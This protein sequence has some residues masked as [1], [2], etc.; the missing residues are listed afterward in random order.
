MSVKANLKINFLLVF[1]LWQMTVYGQHVQ[2]HARPHVGY[3]TFQA[4]EQ[5]VKEGKVSSEEGLLNKFYYAFE[6]G[7]L[8]AEYK[9]DQGFIRCL[10][11]VMAEYAKSNLSQSSKDQIA[12]YLSTSDRSGTAEI[13]SVLSESEKFELRY[14]TSGADSVSVIDENENGIPDYIDKAAAY[15]DS[16]WIHQVEELGFPDFIIDDETYIIDFRNLSG[17]LY[18][19]TESFSGS[20][21][22]VVHSTFNNF[23]RNDD[24]EGDV[25][26]ALKATIAHEMKHAI[27]YTTNRWRG[28]AGSLNWIEMDATLMEEIVFPKVNDYYNYLPSSTSIF[29]APERGTPGAYYHV[30]WSLYFAE[31][32]SMQFWVDVWEKIGID[33]NKLM[34]EA[35]RE[36]LYNNGESFSREFILNY[37]W[38]YASRSRWREDYGF[39]EGNFYPNISLKSTNTGI[40]DSISEKD[41]IVHQAVNFHE[42]IPSDETGQVIV[43]W[44]FDV[45]ES[46]IGLLAF[47]KDG[48][49]KELIPPS[50]D[51][52]SGRVE[53]DWDWSNIESL[54][55]A[56][57]NYSSNSNDTLEMQFQASS[58]TITH[59]IAEID[60]P[61]EVQLDQNYPNPFNPSTQISFSL[62]ETQHASLIVYDVT[63]REVARLAEGTY[64]AGTHTFEFGSNTLS[65]GMYMYRLQTQGNVKTKKMMLVK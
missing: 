43:E 47:K 61:R 55:I 29:N 8:K 36:T 33:H 51:I 35:I 41:T 65:S 39:A 6:P 46:G 12:A 18:G 7:K 54:G 58:G 17:G 42:I 37:M 28:D 60:I 63:G 44:N 45:P 11:P 53:T 56:L 10:T 16:S 21:Y 32:F 2:D 15:A 40:P 22:I 59:P 5:D 27:Q 23:P 1:C 25:L 62:P 49:V 52:E 4:I 19:Y 48:S 64:S 13:K 57:V 26:G 9:N 24:P 20:T 30:T 34:M 50:N 14:W 31:R 38:H 3:E